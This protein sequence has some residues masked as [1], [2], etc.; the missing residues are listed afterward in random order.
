MTNKE[1]CVNME[2]GISYHT[3]DECKNCIGNMLHWFHIVYTMHMHYIILFVVHGFGSDLY[4]VEEGG[5]VEIKLERNLKGTTMFPFLQLFGTI[6][7]D[8]STGK[9]L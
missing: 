3:A 5:T 1:C 7:S 8:N 2:C 4:E 9:F 6:K